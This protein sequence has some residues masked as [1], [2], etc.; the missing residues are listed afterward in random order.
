MMA[1]IEFCGIPGAGKTTLCNA[2]LR[3]LK[4]QGCNILGRD[5]MVARAIRARDYGMIGNLVAAAFPRWRLE[6]LGVPHALPD[7]HRFVASHADFSALLHTWLAAPRTDANWRSDVYYSLLTTAFELQLAEESPAP[8]LLDEGF[9]QRFFSLCGYRGLGQPEDPHRYAATMPRPTA[10]VWVSTP[11]SL[12]LDR[13][14]KRPHLPVLLANESPA[15]QAVR[16]AEG[17]AMLDGLA[18]AL[19][20]NG[21]PVLRAGSTSNP[22]DTARTIATFVEPLLRTP[23]TP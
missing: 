23:H 12:C 16:L 11:P 2:T 19:E 15:T 1:R 7:W 8:Q 22:E 6:F 10:V 5:E 21:V 17:S 14:R 18:T 13:I 3:L 4:H 9:A 20:K